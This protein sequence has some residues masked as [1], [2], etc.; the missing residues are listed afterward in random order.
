MA[1]ICNYSH[2][3]L[4]ITEGLIR[5]KTGSLFPYNPEFYDLASGL[6]GP[7][8]IY[9]WELLL[10]SAILNLAF[11]PM[12]DK[13]R[14]QLY[15][16]SDLLAVVAYPVFAATD[17]LVHA[18]KLLGTEY[19]ALAI[20]CLR[21]PFVDLEGF[22]VFNHTQLDLSN[23]PPDILHLGQRAIDLTG[24]LT[25]CYMYAIV[26]CF[27]LLLYLLGRD[28]SLRPTIWMRRLVV[29]SYG[30][31]LVVLT[32][33]HLSLRNLVISLALSFYEII[34]PILLVFLFA[35]SAA[36]FVAFLMIIFSFG[37]ALWA[38]NK[39]DV[40]KALND[41]GAFFILAWLLIPAIYSVLINGLSLI[42][43]LGISLSERDQLATLI[44]GIATLGFT[45]YDIF[46]H[47]RILRKEA[48]DADELQA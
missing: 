10:V 5:H 15:I 44:V 7:G 9:C 45:V 29:Y 47:R 31:V 8:A 26:F 33:F 16:S 41:F 14:H 39:T 30:Y 12:D 20:F 18:M 1:S 34:L 4:Q 17:V 22:A 27:L 37:K 28:D 24:S 35:V 43:D 36:T 40:K 3:E 46:H 21:Y 19:R 13:G 2:P 38:Q 6:Y 25:I 11:Q 48:R 42:P 32:I 23:V